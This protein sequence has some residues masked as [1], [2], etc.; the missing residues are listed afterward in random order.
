VNI[1]SS[2]SILL[3]REIYSIRIYTNQLRSGPRQPKLIPAL[4]R[5]LDVLELLQRE[6]QPRSLQEIFK[7][8]DISRTTVY[9]ILQTFSHRGYISQSKAGMYRFVA[10]PRKIRFG[11]GAE[12]SAEPFRRL[13]GRV[14]LLLRHPRVREAKRERDVAIVGQDFIPE[15]LDELKSGSCF[16]AS[17][18]HEA[19]S[20]GPQLIELGL[21]ILKGQ[22]VEPYNYVK[23][24]L[25][26]SGEYPKRWK[27][28]K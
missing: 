6:N 5:A 23:H 10:R 2:E 27:G 12:S 28:A 26:T 19:A 14:C 16:I 4:S 20:Y 7:Q 24:K 13:S 1:E 8:T 22:A 25:V 21:A 9:R 11:F 17:V 18:S 3:V 15:T